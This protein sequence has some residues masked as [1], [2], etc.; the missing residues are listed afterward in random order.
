MAAETITDEAHEAGVW[1]TPYPAVPPHT[2]EGIEHEMVDV[3]GPMSNYQ[4]IMG[5]FPLVVGT[6]R[7]GKRD[8][9]VDRRSTGVF[10]RC[11]RC[12]PPD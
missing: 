5:G 10:R 12:Y 8:L 7:C 1:A 6:T 11:R 9:M 2:R 4:N 3:D